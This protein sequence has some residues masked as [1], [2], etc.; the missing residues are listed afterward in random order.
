MSLLYFLNNRQFA[1]KCL[2]TY[3]RIK[4]NGLLDHDTKVAWTTKMWNN[5]LKKFI[6]YSVGEAGFFK[7]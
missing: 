2:I 1:R 4:K 6:K 3:V 7:F 5:Y